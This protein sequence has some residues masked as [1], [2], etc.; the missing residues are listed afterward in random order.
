MLFWNP[1]PGIV[2]G[3]DSLRAVNPTGVDFVQ[4]F[5]IEKKRFNEFRS[6]LRG[7]QDTSCASATWT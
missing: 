4:E 7:R 3:S 6:V 2:I 5:N 1:D